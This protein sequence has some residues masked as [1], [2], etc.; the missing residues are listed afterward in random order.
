M[1]NIKLRAL[2]LFLFAAGCSPGDRGG[3][4]TVFHAGSLAGPMRDL[5][6]RFEELHPGTHVLREASGSRMAARKITQLG[7]EA[8]VLA[9]AD[10]LVIDDLMAP[11]HA[12]WYVMFGRNRMVLAYTQRSA[13]AAEINAENW[14]EILLDPEIRYG[15]SDPDLDPCGYRTWML[16]DLA[17]RYYDV[18]GLNRALRDGCPPGHIRACAIELLPQLES[19]DLDYIFSYES[20][21]RQHHLRFVRFPPEIDLSSPE[22]APHY[23]FT[24]V[25][26][27]GKEPGTT[28]KLTATPIVYAATVPIGAPHRALALAFVELLISEEGQ[29]ILERNFQSVISPARVPDVAAVPERLR[30]LVAKTEVPL[31]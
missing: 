10:Y 24:Q 15:H 28:S 9:I 14:Y 5:A 31:P 4:L 20:V 17:E 6:A 7:R 25:T 18:A 29:Q 19:V 21:A 16:W 26:V 13:R 1:H 22:L 2:L 3:R 12:D 27:S 30:P 23:R 11:E 8:D